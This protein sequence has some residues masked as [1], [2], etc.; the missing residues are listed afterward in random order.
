M[1]RQMGFTGAACYRRVGENLVLILNMES[2]KSQDWPAAIPFNIHYTPGDPELAAGG[3]QRASELQSPGHPW[4]KGVYLYFPEQVFSEQ[5]LVFAVTC[6]SGKRLRTSELDGL[7]EAVAAR[8]RGWMSREAERQDLHEK[9]MRERIAEM[10]GD[11]RSL[12]D[13]ELRTPLSAISGYLSLLKDMPEFESRQ[14]RD[15]YWSVVDG[16]LA[17]IIDSLDRLSMAMYGRRGRGSVGEPG[18]RHAG[19]IN[20]RTIIDELI[21][22]L[23]NTAEEHVSGDIAKKLSL[24]VIQGENADCSIEAEEKMFRWATWEVMK[25]AIVY[26]RSGKVDI[27]IYT[28]GTNVVVDIIDDGAGVSPGTEELIF[29]RFFQEPG[30]HRTRKGKRGLGLGLYLAR[31]IVQRHLGELLYLRTK[32]ATVFRFIWPG[33]D[34]VQNLDDKR[35]A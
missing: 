24:Q 28:V 8:L 16:K 15:E 27:A 11:F 30:K 10:D 1:M 4:K 25:N 35:G 12:V 13:H 31:Q 19:V 6:S 18:G 26:S 20:V 21:S 17:H 3:W 14:V 5:K 22:E 29:L 23:K 9:Y 33:Q 2:E 7:M 32:N 34:A